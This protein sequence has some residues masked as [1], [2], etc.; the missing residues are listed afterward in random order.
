MANSMDSIL[1]KCENNRTIS[2]LEFLYPDKYPINPPLELAETEK[3]IQEA[4]RLVYELNGKEPPLYKR[5]NNRDPKKPLTINCHSKISSGLE[6]YYCDSENEIGFVNSNGNLVESLAHELKHAEQHA[7]PELQKISDGEDNKAKGNIL[8]ID[9]AEAV[10]AG[11]MVGIETG[12]DESKDYYYDKLY[13]QLVHEYTDEKGNPDFPKIKEK[14]MTSFIEEVSRFNILGYYFNQLEFQYPENFCDKGLESVPAHYGVSKDFLKVMKG[15]SIHSCVE[16]RIK[17]M[18]KLPDEM[19]KL[20]ESGVEGE[21]QFIKKL[22][23]WMLDMKTPK[24]LQALFDAMKDEKGNLPFSREVF[25]DQNKCNLLLKTVDDN[26]NYTVWFKSEYERL[27]KTHDANLMGTLAHCVNSE[28]CHGAI[29]ILMALKDKDGKPIISQENI[30][31]FPEKSFLAKDVKAFV[32]KD[33]PQ[34]H[35]HSFTERLAKISNQSPPT[36]E[37][38]EKAFIIKKV[39]AKRQAGG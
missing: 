32:K 27:L 36:S 33:T 1:V 15:I 6:A 26:F 38:V 5:F 13:R 20:K 12:Q 23:G 18:Q 31:Q 37:K 28:Y 29:P 21:K 4:T 22:T 8:L 30:D 9:E 39:N 10:W 17:I 24:N 11:S 7:D 25:E 34:S 2:I 3:K 19:A 16:H 14:M 35:K